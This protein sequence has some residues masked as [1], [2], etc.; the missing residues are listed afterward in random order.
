MIFERRYCSLGLHLIRFFCQKRKSQSQYCVIWGSQRIKVFKSNIL[1]FTKSVSFVQ[2]GL[3][4]MSFEI[5]ILYNNNKSLLSQIYYKYA[6]PSGWELSKK[7]V[8]VSQGF[9][10][11]FGNVA[12][13]WRPVI[14]SNIAILVQVI[15]RKTNCMS[16][17]CHHFVHL[18]I[19]S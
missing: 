12:K 17:E 6:R 5:H 4:I 10:G 2:G 14:W 8:K 3:S 16:R 1:I 19:C 9:S 7:I 18:N 15:V 11:Q 13:H